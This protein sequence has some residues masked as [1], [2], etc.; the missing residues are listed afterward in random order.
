MSKWYFKY[1]LSKRFYEVLT[2]II[3]SW[4]QNLVF[5]SCGAKFEDYLDAENH[6]VTHERVE[7]DNIKGSDQLNS[8]ILQV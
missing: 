3:D 5:C 6:L 8:I 7:V 2:L 4:S 1:Y